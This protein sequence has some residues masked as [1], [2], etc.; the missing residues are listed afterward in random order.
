MSIKTVNGEVF[1]TTFS[2][3]DEAYKKITTTF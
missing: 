3:R 1:F 2:N